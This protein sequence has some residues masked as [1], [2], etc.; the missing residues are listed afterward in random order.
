[1]DFWLLGGEETPG[2]AGTLAIV[3]DRGPTVLALHGQPGTGGDFA[4]LALALDGRCRVVAPDRPGWGSRAGEP[5]GGFAAGAGDAAAVLDREG[6]ERAVVLGFSWGGGVALELVRRHPDRVGALVLA[7]SI[8]PGEP[9]W[10]DRVLALPVAGPAICAGG[11]A[12]TRLALRRQIFHG[13]LAGGMK[14]VDPVHVRRFADHCLA[15]GVLDS[16]M[17][18]QRALVRELPGVLSGLGDV[19]V[20]TVVVKGERDRTIAPGS[21]RRLAEGIPGAELRLIPG[22]GHYLPGASAVVLADAV[23][24][25]AVRAGW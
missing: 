25:V 6:V 4:A 17:V 11:L 18:E 20:P 24:A 12:A 5:A 13:I 7:A 16:F 10:A 1:V 23:T 15:P 14:G 19:R 8:G 9:T 21:A 2:D 3:M 22:A